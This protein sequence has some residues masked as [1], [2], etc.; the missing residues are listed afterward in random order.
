MRSAG[1]QKGELGKTKNEVTVGRNSGKFA[2]VFWNL[3]GMVG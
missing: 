2:V 3:H 1:K